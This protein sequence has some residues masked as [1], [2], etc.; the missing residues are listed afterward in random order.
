L[1]IIEALK[2][3]L[4]GIVQGVTEVLPISSSGHVEIAKTLMDIQFCENLIFLI[5][6]NTGSLVTFVYIY[7][8]RLW[9]LIKGFVVYIF[10]KN[11]R[12]ANK[13]EFVMM[14]KIIVAS[15]PAGVV[16]VFFN[17][18]IDALLIQYGLLIVGIGL[19]ITA[20]VLYYI[21]S[22]E[23]FRSRRNHLNWVDVLLMG[24]AQAVAL[25]PGVSRSGMTSSTALKRGSSVDSAL[26]FSFIM[27]IPVSIG[28]LLLMIYKAITEEQSIFQVGQALNYTLA[29]LGAILA[30]YVAYKLIFNIFKSGKL[31]NFSYYCLLASMFAI[32]LYVL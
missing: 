20:S 27:Y 23:P 19:L 9:E 4:L 17:D 13:S 11:Q 22:E 3:L 28:S 15:I 18:Q 16:G 1:S 14:M 29:F 12:E 24:L 26:N 2:Y 21:T 5:L 6:V 25:F 8:K 7:R 32:I 30:T 31:R 10:S